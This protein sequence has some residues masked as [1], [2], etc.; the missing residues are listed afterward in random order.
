VVVLFS[1]MLHGVNAERVQRL[2]QILRMDRRTLLRWREWW[3]ETFVQ[4]RFWQAARAFFMP[5]VCEQTLP[6]S[7]AK[8]YGAEQRNRFMDLLKFLAPLT[9]PGARDAQVM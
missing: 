1:A 7:L 8:H 3:L 6:W 2:R 5:P 4:T 9:V